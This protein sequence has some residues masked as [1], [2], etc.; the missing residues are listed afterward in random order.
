MYN[1]ACDAWLA[2]PPPSQSHGFPVHRKAIIT[3]LIDKSGHGLE[4]GPSHD[5]VAPKADGFDVHI[6]DHMSQDELRGKYR[7][8]GINLNNIE[9]VDF[10]SKGEPLRELL[11]TSA[12]YD[13]IIASHV[14]EHMPNMLRFLM[15]CQEVLKPGGVLSLAIPDQRFCLDYLRPVSTTGDILQAFLEKRTR[16]TAG[17]VFDA[18]AFAG[19]VNGALAWS[20]ASQGRLEFMHDHGLA[21]VQLQN[22]LRSDEYVDVHGWVFTPHSFRLVV[23]DLAD[24]GYLR[25]TE[26][27][28]TPTIGCEFFLSYRN[29]PSPARVD[30]L[31]L[32]KAVKE[33]A[34]QAQCS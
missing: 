9:H 31:G 22:Y 10:I 24:I 4:M 16:H 33:E 11:G 15:D 21:A 1:G 30:R 6:V 18:F 26:A 32:A 20:Q 14:I 7:G 29:S 28:F 17:Q 3:A 19:T 34:R 5:P 25:L 23:Q 13:W 8:H 2:S 12:S 27:A